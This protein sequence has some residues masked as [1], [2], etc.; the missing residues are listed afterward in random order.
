MYFRRRIGIYT[1]LLV[2]LGVTILP[3]GQ[4][5]A[6]ATPPVRPPLSLTTSPLPLNVSTKPGQ[7]V[8]ADIRVK[9]NGT[10][11]ELL[12]ID[13]MKFGAAGSTGR[14]QLL[15]RGPQDQYFNWVSFS[16]PTFVAQ[17]NVWKTIHMNIKPPKEAAF[18]YYY[19]VVFSRANPDKPTAGNSAVEGG[20]ASLVLLTVEAPGAR[21]DAQITDISATQ[22]VYEFL[23]A[24]I[25]VKLHNGG[26]LH[27]SPTGTMF[28]KRGS[29]QVAAIDF[30]SEQ[31][32]ILPG[33]DREFE[34]TWND[35]FP[36]YKET[37]TGNQATKKLVWDFSKIQKL[38]FGRY[39]ANLVAVYD[40]GQRDVPVEAVVSF[41]VIPWRILGVIFLIILLIIA[42][43]WGVGRLIWRGVRRQ[44][45][46]LPPAGQG[47]AAAAATLPT[48]PKPEDSSLA[49][50]LKKRGR[51]KKDKTAQSDEQPS[52]TPATPVETPQEA[53]VKRGRGRPPKNAASVSAPIPTAQEPAVQSSA[54]VVSPPATKPG[55]KPSAHKPASRVSTKPLATK[56][57]G[58][59]LAIKPAPKKKGS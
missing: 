24:K 54:P 39:T 33:T 23:P 17:P 32:N 58:K 51:K 5:F 35:G 31:G 19:A 30:N 45:V 49:A 46:I 41:W 14:P 16:E 8:T 47:P 42:G 1:A 50:A 36:S 26:N 10:Q 28:I 2:V 3:A 43:I 37:G 59:R 27:V 6:Q 11:D 7:P 52:E 22:K 34:M 48:E 29:A 12:K 4:V 38:R 57:G 21:R 13:L 9:N 55:R 15:D 25:T 44:V 20:V 53:P 56:P 18:G 40:D